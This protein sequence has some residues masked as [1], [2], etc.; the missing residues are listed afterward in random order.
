M[1]FRLSDYLINI[2]GSTVRQLLTELKM[3]V[4]YNIV[5]EFE[6]SNQWKYLR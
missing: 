4:V 6:I 5:L 1:A 2:N 3:I